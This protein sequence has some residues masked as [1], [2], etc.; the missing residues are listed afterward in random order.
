MILYIFVCISY[1]CIYMYHDTP[2]MSSFPGISIIESRKNIWISMDIILVRSL[3]APRLTHQ[4]TIRVSPNDTW[5]KC[6][7]FR[8]S[9]FTRV[10]ELQKMMTCE[11]WKLAAV[12]PVQRKLGTEAQVERSQVKILVQ[13]PTQCKFTMIICCILGGYFGLRGVSKEIITINESMTNM[14]TA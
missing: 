14:D 1:A 11:L 6:V 12:Y 10:T 8:A 3:L 2:S 5:P 13:Q 7:I 4:L 9:N